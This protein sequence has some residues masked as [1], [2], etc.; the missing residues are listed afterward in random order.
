MLSV[1]SPLGSD[2]TP[3]FVFMPTTATAGATAAV[4]LMQEKEKTGPTAAA[5][6]LVYQL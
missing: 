3:I 2:A 1:H 6:E 4:C 5:T